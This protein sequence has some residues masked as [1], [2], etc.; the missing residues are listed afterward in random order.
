[1]Y[2][3]KSREMNFSIIYPRLPGKLVHLCQSLKLCHLCVHLNH[4]TLRHQYVKQSGV[5][6]KP[7]VFICTDKAKF[8]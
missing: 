1:M 8:H 4:P 3:K 6:L 5:L 2:I 7:N